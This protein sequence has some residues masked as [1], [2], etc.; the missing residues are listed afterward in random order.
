[1]A[2]E[3][4][5]YWTF[6]GWPDSMIEDWQNKIADIFQIPVSY[7]VHDKDKD[8][9]KGD[10]KVHVHF[11]LAFP[12]TTTYNHV[13]SLCREVMPTCAIVKKVINIRYMYDYLIHDTDSCRKAKKHLYNKNE[14]I[15][16]N[17]FDIGQ[18]EQ[19][20]LEEKREDAKLLKK[21]IID[22]QIENTMELDIAL[23]SDSDVDQDLFDRFEDVL[24]GYSGYINNIC[25]GVYLYK[26]K[27]HNIKRY[28]GE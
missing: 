4:A 26:C 16:L 3:K 8:G 10:R 20:S 24:I 1:M 13:L 19:R 15:L 17:N 21:Y 12:N 18:F 28:Y 25:K 7:C 11:I 5:K 14:R 6:I 27:Q 2:V 22:H 23:N 9:H